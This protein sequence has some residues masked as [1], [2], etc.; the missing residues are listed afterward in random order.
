VNRAALEADPAL[1]RAYREAVGWRGE[2]EEFRRWHERRPDTPK[3][4]AAHADD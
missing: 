4:R 2:P 3:E 1:W